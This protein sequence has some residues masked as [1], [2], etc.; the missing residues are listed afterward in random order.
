MGSITET[1][2]A[3][4]ILNGEAANASLKEMDKYAKALWASLRNM[5]TTSKEFVDGTKKYQE[6]QGRIEKVR[7]EIKGTSDAIGAMGIAMTG[8]F[9]DMS[10]KLDLTNMSLG[11]MKKAFIELKNTSIGGKSA[12]DVEALKLRMGELKKGIKDAA[13]EMNMLGTENAAVVVGGLKFISAGI[14]GIV[15]SLSVMGVESETIKQ[16]EGK[17]TSL[18]ALTQSLSEIEDAVTSGKLKSIAVRIQ[19]MALDVKDTVVRWANSVATTSQANAEAAR[20]GMVTGETLA[21]RAASAAQWLWNAALAANPIGLVVMAV[22]ALAAGVYLLAKNMK[23]ETAEVARSSAAREQLRQNMQIF[24][25]ELKKHMLEMAK[26]KHEDTAYDQASEEYAKR[27]YEAKI[28]REKALIEVSKI[29]DPMERAQRE[30]ATM[31][32]FNG[33][34]LFAKEEF[35][36]KVAK[37]NQKKR[38]EQKDADDKQFEEQ[39]KLQQ[40]ALN[41]KEQKEK[42]FWDKIINEAGKKVEEYDAAVL[43]GDD[44]IQAEKDKNAEATYQFR[45]EQGIATQDEILQHDMDAVTKSKEFAILSAEE[46]EKVLVGV[47]KRAM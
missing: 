4:V 35:E 18:I 36:A 31:N 30:E 40:K 14:E 42:A 10:K 1:A 26:L 32:I 7:D 29:S 43:K 2:R 12:E 24:Y 17:M 23:A 46:K 21:V 16:L 25:I 9:A 3:E 34:M 28:K 8:S 44:Q 15:G 41:E 22:A 13:V 19:S 37:I 38:D 39:D 27:I 47:H 5:D 33:H 6:V 11:E 45:L 20:A